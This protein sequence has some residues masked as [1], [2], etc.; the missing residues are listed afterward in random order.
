MQSTAESSA[1]NNHSQIKDLISRFNSTKINLQI[2]DN[3]SGLIKRYLQS[4]K[5]FK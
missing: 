2:K 4:E 5:V 3:Q 1:L